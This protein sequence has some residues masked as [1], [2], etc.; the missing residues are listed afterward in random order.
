MNT[1]VII[2]EI[3]KRYGIDT[4]TRN[5]VLFEVGSAFVKQFSQGVFMLKEPLFWTVWK[6]IFLADDQ[7]VI[8]CAKPLTVNYSDLKMAMAVDATV[9]AEFCKMY[10]AR[11]RQTDKKPAAVANHEPSELNQWRKRLIAAIGGWLRL[12]GQVESL[13]KITGIACR[14]AAVTDFNDIS[15]ERLISLYNAFLQKQRDLNAVRDLPA[16]EANNQ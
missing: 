5:T 9:K 16:T 12:S 14:A 13:A 3:C 1:E 8:A 15:K 7:A 4:E 10:Y 2:E 11:Q 6:H